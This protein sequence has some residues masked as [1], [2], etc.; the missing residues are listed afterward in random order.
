[1]T[2]QPLAIIAAAGPGVGLGVARLFAEKG[3]RLALIAR[4]KEPLEGYIADLP[5]GAE[6]HRAFS[7]DL[8]QLGHTARVFDQIIDEMGPADLMVWNASRWNQKPAIEI[9]PEEFHAD[10][11][12]GASS[13]LVAV[14]KVHPGMKAAGRGTIIMT[15]GGLAL[16]PSWAAPVISLGTAKAALRAMTHA[17]AEPL[18]ADG[19]HVGT[20]II[21]GVVE[22]GT[23][24][25][26]A[27]IAP[28]F[29]TLYT[30][31]P[32]AWEVERVFRGKAG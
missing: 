31:E 18:K 7:A 19:I 1:M 8:S 22:A 6:R 29:W 17:L 20:V 9:D 32:D 26:P 21:A 16:N 4:R 11:A 14:Q 2:D 28:E 30:Q 15:G 13:A 27:H 12:L 23:P 25:D 3:F 5:G 10:L 24:F